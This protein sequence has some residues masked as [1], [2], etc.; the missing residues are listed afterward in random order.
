VSAAAALDDVPT[1]TAIAE[2]HAGLTTAMERERRSLDRFADVAACLED[3][4]EVGTQA[5]D[6]IEVFVGDDDPIVVRI[7]AAIFEP[8]L[9]FST[10]FIDDADATWLLQTNAELAPFRF[11]SSDGIELC[12]AFPLAGM[13]AQR[14][15]EIVE[16]L[17]AA[18]DRLIDEANAPE[19]WEEETAVVGPYAT[20]EACEAAL[21]KEFAELG[22]KKLDASEPGA[23]HAYLHA[24]GEGWWISASTLLVSRLA[25]EHPRSSIFGVV[26]TDDGV[27]LWQLSLGDGRLDKHEAL[28]SEVDDSDPADAALDW[29]ARLAARSV[30]ASTS[31]LISRPIFYRET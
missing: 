29:E 26:T 24:I 27:D 2:M 4:F 3:V 15:I 23:E 14:L 13:S 8:W 18:R 5:S 12:A 7:M 16:D 31:Q 17:D 11:E 30:G 20:R 28:G 19:P 22:W 9:H 6:E 1:A 21:E 25:W 10:P